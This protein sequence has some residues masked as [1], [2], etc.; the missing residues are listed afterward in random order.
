MDVPLNYEE[1]I[2]CKRPVGVQK[3]IVPRFVLT[4][5]ETGFLWLSGHHTVLTLGS[6]SFG[7]AWI[8]PEPV[9]FFLQLCRGIS[10]Q[11]VHETQVHCALPGGVPGDSQSRVRT[12]L[13]VTSLVCNSAGAYHP[14][15][16]Q[17]P[18]FFLNCHNLGSVC[19]L[20]H[21]TSS[22]PNQNDLTAGVL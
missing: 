20:R 18:F 15:R 14:S 10:G 11:P 2:R 3:C 1:F 8:S 12:K 5:P 6:A 16:L 19:G 21:Q 9:F 22:F 13:S 17:T 7:S 4:V